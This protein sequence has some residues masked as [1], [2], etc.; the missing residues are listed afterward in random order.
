[1]N[2]YC[3]WNAFWSFLMFGWTIVYALVERKQ[4][5]TF[6]WVLLIIAI[7][8]AFVSAIVYNKDLDK[9]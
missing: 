7:V 5:N 4:D 3:I 8:L 2:A 6:L 9:K 1:M